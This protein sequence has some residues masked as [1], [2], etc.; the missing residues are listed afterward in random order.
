MGATRIPI[1]LSHSYRPEDRAVNR[2]FWE[3]FWRAG[4]AFTVDPKSTDQLSIPHLEL[5]MQRSAGFVAIAP[6][7]P[8]QERY[9]TSPYIVFEHNMAVRAKKPRLV[10]AEARVAGH[11]YDGS[12]VSVFRRDDPARARDLARY[13]EE[14]REQCTPHAESADHVLGS[15]GLVMP[16]GRSYDRAASAVTDVL[17]SAGY[18]VDPLRFEP[19]RAP[20]FSE[21]DRHDFFVIDIRAQGMASGLYYRFVPTIRLG[22][23]SD[24]GRVPALPGMFR[25]DALERAGGSAQTVL[26]WNREDEL[27]GQLQ[28][29]V[30]K[31]QRPRREFQTLDEGTGYFQSLGRALQGPVFISNAKRQNDVALHVSRGLDLNNIGFFHYRF[32]NSIPMGT[33]WEGQLLQRLRSSRLFVALI[34]AEYWESPLCRQEFHMAQQLAAQ[35]RLSVYKY[36]L[37]EAND[38]D[39]VADRLQGKDLSGLTP[40]EQLSAIVL[41]VD[42]Y[43]TVGQN[44]AS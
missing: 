27:L 1:Y 39:G 23:Q 40:E 21:I 16:P 25:D 20:D 8:D 38:T 13:V 35:N 19:T 44:I 12:P 34:T 3:V 41:D 42:N 4:F 37:D 14:L 11:P 30:D 29:I 5:M 7:R 24:N 2:F 10:L 33:V 32:K 28:P 36:F 17:E 31:I 15:V 18:E 9:K 26:W 43:L 22:Y 6:Y